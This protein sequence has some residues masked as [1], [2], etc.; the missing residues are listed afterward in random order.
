MG[1]VLCF[2]DI[3]LN[4]KDMIPI[5]TDLPNGFSLTDLHDLNI[6]CVGLPVYLCLY[7]SFL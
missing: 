7:N 6:A 3:M 1:T 5:L 4:K 2:Q